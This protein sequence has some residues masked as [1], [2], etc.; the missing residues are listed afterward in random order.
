M[1]ALN[2]ANWPSFRHFF[3]D[4]CALHRLEDFELGP[5]AAMKQLFD[6]AFDFECEI[7]QRNVLEKPEGT[8]HGEITDWIELKLA[9]QAVQNGRPARP[10]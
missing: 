2:I 3:G 10:Q 6:G 4:S 8:G 7:S 9:P 1:S 5:C